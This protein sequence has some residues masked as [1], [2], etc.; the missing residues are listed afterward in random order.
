MMNKKM[1]YVLTILYIAV[2]AVVIR[3]MFPELDYVALSTVTVVVA[4]FISLLAKLLFTQIKTVYKKID[5]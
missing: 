3:S 1:V 5:E 2:I 4:A